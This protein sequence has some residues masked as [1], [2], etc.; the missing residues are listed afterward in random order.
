MSRIA[1]Q[2]NLIKNSSLAD[3]VN[4]SHGSLKAQPKSRELPNLNYYVIADQIDKLT[5]SVFKNLTGESFQ[6]ITRV[7]FKES[8]F[9]LPADSYVAI[10][11]IN[12]H[13]NEFMNIPLDYN[14][15]T[16]MMSHPQNFQNKDVKDIHNR[17]L[18]DLEN[19]R[20]AWITKEHISQPI[21]VLT[22]DGKGAHVVGIL[23]YYRKVRDGKAFTS[24]DKIFLRIIG[25]CLSYIIYICKERQRTK[26]INNTYAM[27]A[28]NIPDI[29][30]CTDLSHMMIKLRLSLVD[31]FKS[32]DCAII[33]WDEHDKLFIALNSGSSLAELRKAERTDLSKFNNAL[34]ISGMVYRE[35]VSQILDKPRTSPL[36]LAEID[37][38][39]P[40]KFLGNFLIF[41]ANDFQKMGFISD[42]KLLTIIFQGCFRQSIKRKIF[43]MRDLR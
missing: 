16:F 33:L 1:E 30:K 13:T 6:D 38:L 15:K 11:D 35:G 39:T 8:L 31:V 41:G 32:E 27:F 22:D 19:F 21:R 7:L 37:N 5:L 3:N 43:L 42:W 25:F 26:V 12:D 10:F 40:V 34:G 17:L 28:R 23:T 4:K 29:V 24:I 36:F 2:G 18:R 20:E 14:K 9:T